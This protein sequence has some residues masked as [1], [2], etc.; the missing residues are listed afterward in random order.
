MGF[1]PESIWAAFIMESLLLSS[2][3]AALGCA[4]AMLFNGIQ[5]GT[6]NLTTFSETAFEFRVT[7]EILCKAV[8]VA[9]VMG[10]IGGLLPAMRA[11]RMKVVDALR[12]A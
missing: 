3:G 12:R 6:T 11:A 1:T 5:T 10:F 8:I 7:P 4:I 9:L 2:I